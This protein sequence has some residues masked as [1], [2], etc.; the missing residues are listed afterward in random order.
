[1]SSDEESDSESFIPFTER[2]EWK[3]VKPLPQDDGPDPVVSILYSDEFRETMDMFRAILQ[4]DE[5]SE[6]ALKLTEEVVAVNAAN[7]T[8]WHFRRLLLDDLK[9]DLREELRFIGDKI[10]RSPKNY[11]VWYH[12][13]AVVE[14]L[15]D[16]SEEFNF[17]AE[18]LKMDAKNYH[19]W[20]HRHWVVEQF[21]KGDN[22]LQ[23]ADQ[24][25][26]EDIRNNSVWNYRYFIISQSEGFSEAVIKRELAYSFALAKKAPNNESVWN[27]IRGLVVDK[28]FESFPEVFDFCT[29]LNRSQVLYPFCLGLLV[30][31]YEQRSQKGDE[32]ALKEV[33]KLCDILGT[34]IDTI[35]SKYWN[36]R[37][38]VIQ[39]TFNKK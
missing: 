24:L 29:E 11:Q 3:D 35:R 27:Y 32:G 31:I 30:E 16:P 10:S 19:A 37:K 14:K 5:R 21:K 15:G 9:K 17:T 33:E 34:Q 28:G 20:T 12:R 39:E 7:Y 23:F 13:R 1:M 18:I 38:V 2:E 25:L 6:R 4:L 36:Y 22:E 26:K 8:A